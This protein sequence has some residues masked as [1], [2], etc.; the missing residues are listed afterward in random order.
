MKRTTSCDQLPF[1]KWQIKCWSQTMKYTLGLDMGVA[2]LGWAVLSDDNQ[3]IESGVRIFP[4]GIDKFGTG[5]DTHLNQRRGFLSL[6]KSEVEAAEGEDKKKLEGMLGAMETLQDTI[7]ATF[8][9]TS[10]RTLGNYLHHLRQKEGGTHGNLIRLRARHIRRDMLHHEF[11]LIWEEQSKHH[12]ELNDALRLIDNSV[13]G[14]PAERKL[15]PAERAVALAY[16]SSTQKPTLKSLKGKIAKLPDSPAVR[17]VTFNLEAD[18]RDNIGGLSTELTN[19]KLEFYNPNFPHVNN[20]LVLRSL[21]ELRKVVNGIIAKYGPP[22][23]IH[24]EMARDLKMSARQRENYV[25]KNNEHKKS[26]ELAIRKLEE[27]GIAPTRDAIL[28][29]RLWQEQN[30][31]CI[32]DRYAASDKRDPES[33]SFFNSALNYGYAIIRAS[34]AR[35]LVSAGLHPALGVFHHRR[36]NPFCL[37]DDVMEPLRPLVDRTVKI[38]LA[39]SSVP[40]DGTLL[41]APTPRRPVVNTPTFANPFSKTISL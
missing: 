4:A 20:P 32:S 3:F 6:R 39:D 37:A 28:L 1:S 38:L 10:D 33:E 35:A 36:N 8:P 24:L 23:H 7:D 21:H 27:Y 14:K 29:Y 34:V 25:K 41:T 5:K 15:A 16:F 30:E 26:R 40:Q 31:R 13:E 12:P 9:N 22:T 18:K 19:P 17:Q 2:S 11:S